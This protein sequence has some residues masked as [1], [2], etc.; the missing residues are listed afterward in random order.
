VI[1]ERL[2]VLRAEIREL[3]SIACAD[4]G[5]SF[6]NHAQ[7]HEPSYCYGCRCKRFVDPA[8]ILA[9]DDGPLVENVQLEEGAGL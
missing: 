2:A 6:R 3:C 9:F 1:A 5:H 7:T 8:E 4:C